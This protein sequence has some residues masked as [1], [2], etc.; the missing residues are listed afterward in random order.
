MNKIKSLFV[1]I[2]LLSLCSCFRSWQPVCRHDAI[3]AASVVGEE[4]PVRLIAGDIFGVKHIRAQACID[5]KWEWIEPSHAWIVIGKN[6]YR[7]KENR[8]YSFR[9]YVNRLKIKL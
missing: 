8:I 1:L 9:E 3:Y 4:H 6:D 2:L 5:G 7:F